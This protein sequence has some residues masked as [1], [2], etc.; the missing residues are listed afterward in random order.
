M[1]GAHHRP[2]GGGG[3]AR[4]KTTKRV[5]FARG[6]AALWAGLT[7]AALKWWPDSVAFVIIMSGYANVVS[8][9]SVAEAADDTAV[10]ERL[11]RL[12]AALK[13]RP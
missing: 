13:E 1:G 2:G 11:D 4:R 6:R 3:V 8:D 5:W 12:E 9:L 10:L 7:L